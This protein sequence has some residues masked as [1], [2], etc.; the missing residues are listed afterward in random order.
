MRKSSG[1]TLMEMIVVIVLLGVFAAMVVP[2]VTT[3]VERSRAAEATEVLTKIYA[4]RLRLLDDN[5][6]SGSV[7]A[8]NF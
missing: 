1:F 8:A 4:G 5:S 3:M 6:S 7:T 2:K